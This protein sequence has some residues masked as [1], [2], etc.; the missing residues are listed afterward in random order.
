MSASFSCRSI[1]S[2]MHSSANTSIAPSCSRTSSRIPENSLEHSYTFKR[3]SI[4]ISLLRSIFKKSI[5]SR[6]RIGFCKGIARCADCRIRTDHCTNHQIW[7]T[8][9]CKDR[10]I[11]YIIAIWN[12]WLQ[13]ES[14]RRSPTI[15]DKIANKIENDMILLFIFRSTWN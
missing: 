5:Q 2:N 13:Q 11:R 12:W 4:F 8:G 1:A 9:I 15:V 3:F 6:G 14:R 10:R 7:Q